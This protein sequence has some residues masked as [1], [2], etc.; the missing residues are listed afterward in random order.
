MYSLEDFEM[1]VEICERTISSGLVCK[2]L[3]IT[4]KL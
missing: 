1:G 2:R 4:K 3:P